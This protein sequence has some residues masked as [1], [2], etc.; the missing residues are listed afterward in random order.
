MS[1]YIREHADL[2]TGLE[3]YVHLYDELMSEPLPPSTTVARELD[4]YLRHTASRMAQMEIELGQYRQ[5]HRMAPLSDAACAQLR[6]RIE[7]CPESV[8]CGRTAAVRVE[9]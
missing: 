6:L 9:V 4:E 8:V 5:P 1:R 7:H 2:S 3:Q